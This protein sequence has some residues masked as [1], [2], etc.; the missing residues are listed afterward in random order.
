MAGSLITRGFGPGG[1]HGMPWAGPQGGPIGAP[2]IGAPIIGAP[3]IG[4]PI[5]GIM[6]GPQGF[7][8]VATHGLLTGALGALLFGLLF[9]ALGGDGTQGLPAMGTHGGAPIGGMPK[10]DTPIPIRGGCTDMLR[11]GYV[12]PW[13]STGLG[14][15]TGTGAAAGALPLALPFPFAPFFGAAGAGRQGLNALGTHGGAIGSG[16]NGAGI[17]IGIGGG[18]EDIGMGGDITG[19]GQGLPAMGTHGLEGMTARAL[20]RTNRGMI[21]LYVAMGRAW[22]PRICSLGTGLLE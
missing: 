16:G 10:G 22:A 15:A 8:W 4:A 19:T 5:P 14:A 2:I 12:T 13:M 7:I 3:I 17:G 11:L 6:G 18:I 20:G 21:R 9:T 1:L